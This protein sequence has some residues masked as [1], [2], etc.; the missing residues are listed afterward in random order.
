[1]GVAV[2]VVVGVFAS[3][4]V[5]LR[6]HIDAP[7][8]V[9]SRRRSIVMVVVLDDALALDDAWGG[10]FVSVIALAIDRSIEIC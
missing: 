10:T 1:M 2:F 3:S 6:L 5:D 4:V 8:A 7:L 9:D